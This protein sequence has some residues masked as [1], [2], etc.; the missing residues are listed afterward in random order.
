MTA[1]AQTP[2]VQIRRP[3]REPKKAIELSIDGQSVKV[4]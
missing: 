3:D 4:P 1:H 2:F